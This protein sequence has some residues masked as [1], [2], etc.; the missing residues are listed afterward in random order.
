[1]FVELNDKQD[2][3]QLNF[4][5]DPAAV[6]SVKAIPGARF[7]PQDKGGPHW[8]VPRDMVTARAI[9]KAFPN[10]E[11]GIGVTA[12][13]RDEARLERNLRS[14]TTADDVPVEDLLMAA[15]LPALAEWFRPYQRAD[16]KFLAAVDTLNG[17]QQGLGK[18]AEM[19]GAIYEA[20]LEHGLHLVVGMKTSLD[21][22]WRFEYERWAKDIKVITYSGDLPAKQRKT[23]MEDLRYCVERNEPMVFVCTAHS[24]REHAMHDI[25]WTTYTIDEF[26]KHG[27]ANISGDVNKGTQFGRAS[28][29]IK[30]ERKWLMS[31]TPMGGKPIKLWGAFRFLH[32]ETYTSK[33]RW[34]ETWLEVTKPGQINPLTG[35]KA[36]GWEINGLRED[37]EEEFYAAHARHMVRRLKSEVLPQL[38]PKQYVDVWCKMTP[39]QAKQYEQF[40]AEAE[41]RIDEERLTA[42]GVLAEY[43]RL[44]FFSFSACDVERQH[45]AKDCSKCKGSGML[46]EDVCYICRGE[47]K[48]DH[49]K[50]KPTAESGKIPALLERLAEAGIDPKDPDGD[51]VAV[52]FSQSL[53]IVDFVHKYLNDLGILT[54]K[55]TGNVKQSKRTEVQ[56]EF[57]AGTGARVV[58]MTTQA[59]GVSITLDRADTVHILDE[60]WVPDD[61]EQAEDRIHR[62]SRMHQVT[63]YYYRTEDT[64]DV[65][66]AQLAGDKASGNEKILDIRRNGYKATHR[67][68]AA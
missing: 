39:K 25:E 4:S 41:V 49:L 20:D 5:Y 56:A 13:G 60:T 59:G 67:K 10:A 45:L 57:Q 33:W 18:T 35:K 1:M 3:I 12:W 61:Q 63:C 7:V 37:K 29:E 14:L 53:E 42:K 68:K 9:R 31:G 21:S 36:W 15:K 54:E 22:V 62:A 46:G 58:V 24:I 30:A 16:V 8:L 43:A 32:P 17:N 26:H 19:I 38:P 50:L 44:K 48:V 27:L 2:R 28:M 47:G 65:E 34:A 52:V 23:A 6:R 40:A 64:V 11:F 51:A 66:I 55:I